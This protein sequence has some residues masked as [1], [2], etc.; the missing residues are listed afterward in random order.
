MIMEYIPQQTAVPS[1][2]AVGL[3]ADRRRAADDIRLDFGFQTL[4]GED[5]GWHEQIRDSLTCRVSVP[6]S[7]G[8]QTV[9]VMFFPLSNEVRN[10]EIA[11]RLPII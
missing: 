3:A 6:G 5:N 8:T 11:E 9:R 10:V 1:S 4:A 2:A 7:P